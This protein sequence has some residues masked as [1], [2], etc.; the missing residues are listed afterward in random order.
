[1]DLVPRA[2]VLVLLEKRAVLPLFWGGTGQRWGLITG[3]RRQPSG[4]ELALRSQWPDRASRA[5]SC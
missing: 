1:M 2:F 3:I 4:V 5:K